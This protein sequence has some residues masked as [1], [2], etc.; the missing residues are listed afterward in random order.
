MRRMNEKFELAG[1]YQLPAG[2]A[3]KVVFADSWERVFAKFGFESFD[4]FFDYSG[5]KMVNRNRK[6]NVTILTLGD[7]ADA[8]TFFMKRF[9]SPHYKDMLSAWY[10]FGQPISQA[11]VEWNNAHLL[12]SHGIG[13]YQP[14]CFGE[15]K[16]WGLEKKSFFI[17]EKLNSTEFVEFISQSWQSLKRIQ[18]QKIVTAIAKLIRRIHDRNIVLPDLSVWHIFISEDCLSGQFQLSIID[19]HRMRQNV[20]NQSKRIKDL[21]K[22]S[23]SMSGKYF[24]DELK[25]LFLIAYM[26][27]NWQGN[28]AVSAK[29]VQECAAV[30]AK[31]RKPKCY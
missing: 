4:D 5:G 29:K 22:F 26:R 9:H 3:D 28:K 13:T 20:Q 18:Q 31:R 21:G 14:V 11:A 2:G 17:T 24:D 12:L 1:K 8:K 10:H 30:I 25:D 6:R 19:L 16:R 15:Q 23:W 7:G 27:D